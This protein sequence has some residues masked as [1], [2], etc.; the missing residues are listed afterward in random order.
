MQTTNTTELRKKMR[1]TLDMVSNDKE[2][3]IVH[4]ADKEDVVM[5]P[6]SHYNMVEETLHPYNK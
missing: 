3:V 4:R 1:S 5:I 2:T 6:L